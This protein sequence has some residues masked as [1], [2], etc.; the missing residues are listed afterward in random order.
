MRNEVAASTSYVGNETP[1]GETMSRRT[2]TLVLTL[3]LLLVLAACG[4]GE[5]PSDELLPQAIEIVREH[6]WASTSFLQRKLRIG[7]TRAARLIEQ[8]ERAGL[9]SPMQ[10]NGNREVLAPAPKE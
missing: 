1:K 8:M 2:P 9:V 5:D 10:T 6:Q 3:A 7:Y 4:N